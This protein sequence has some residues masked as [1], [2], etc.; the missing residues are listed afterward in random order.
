VTSRASGLRRAF[1][2]AFARPVAPPAEAGIEHLIVVAGTQTC[3]IRVGELAGLD[4]NRRITPVPRENH[5][6]LGLSA[7]RGTLVPVF[8]LG[9][10]L[11]TASPGT[12]HRWIA[13]YRDTELVGLAFDEWL[14]TRRIAAGDVHP[15]AFPG[16]HAALSPHAIQIDERI[17]HVVDIPAVVSTIRQAFRHR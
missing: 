5:G 3:A 4:V 11:S 12:S 6:L 7:V 15:S 1:D 14:E 17:V 2:D 16:E 10:V 13:L 8:D 9:V